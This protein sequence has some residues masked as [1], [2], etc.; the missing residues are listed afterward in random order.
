MVDEYIQHVQF[1]LACAVCRAF[2]V[3]CRLPILRFSSLAEF[4]DIGGQS[5]HNR[6][7]QLLVTRVRACV[8]MS[9]VEAGRERRK[10]VQMMQQLPVD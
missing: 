4:S 3:G 1:L 6:V 8:R 7:S 5:D 2:I 10:S 9:S